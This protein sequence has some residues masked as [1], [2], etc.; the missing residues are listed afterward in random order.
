MING[1]QLALEG[2]QPVLIHAVAQILHAILQKCTLG[3]LYMHSMTL[4]SFHYLCK[5][6]QML[7]LCAGCNE[8]IIEIAN[9]S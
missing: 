4:E 9:N 8:D 1:I 6:V 2:V 3:T 7:D 5:A